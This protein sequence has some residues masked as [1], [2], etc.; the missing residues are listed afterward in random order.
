MPKAVRIVGRSSSI[1]NSFVNGIISVIPPTAEQIDEA[2]RRHWENHRAILDLMREAK[3]TA[4]LIRARIASRADPLQPPALA[5][6][7]EATAAADTV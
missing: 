2:L 3:K 4:G 7:G 5:G 1:T 6:E